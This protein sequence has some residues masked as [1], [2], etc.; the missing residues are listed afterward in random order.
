MRYTDNLNLKKPEQTEFYDV[1]DFNENA[2]K[3]DA[4]MMKRLSLSGGTITGTITS[5]SDTIL[6]KADDNSGLNLT[7]GKDN[8]SANL[9]LFGKS[10]PEFKGYFALDAL[11]DTGKYHQLLGTPDGKLSWGG[12]YFIKSINGNAADENGVLNVTKL[13]R[14]SYLSKGVNLND[15]QEIGVYGID[16]NGVAET[17]QNIP[18]PL[19]GMLE[20]KHSASDGYYVTQEYTTCDANTRR[21]VRNCYIKNQDWGE[22]VE[23]ITNKTIAT[24]TKYGVVRMATEEDALKDDVQDAAITPAVYHDVSDFRHKQTAYNLGDKVECMFNHELFLECTK[25]G[26]TASTPLDTR[27]VKYGQVLTDGTAQ[28]TVRTHIKSVNNTVA[29]ANGNVNVKE[30]THPNSGVQAGTYDSVTVNAQGH[31]TGGSNPTRVQ[32]VSISGRTITITFTDG[33]TKQLTTQD[34]NTVFGGNY[35]DLNFDLTGRMT[36]IYNGSTGIGDIQ[37]SQPYTNFKALLI[38]TCTDN[39]W[40]HSSHLI[41]VYELQ[42]RKAH[43]TNSRDYLLVDGYSFWSIAYE[44]STTTLIGSDDNCVIRAIYGIK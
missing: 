33:S 25:A 38:I 16:M 23:A 43:V 21:F 34:T 1:D 14:T 26:T 4:E 17:I 20:V 18:V 42:Q 24:S 8:S 44:S 3:I 15:Y 6:N 5:S 40:K 9:T 28:W 22:W 35:A 10:A 2:D 12:A 39:W 11:D 31:V 41:S 27:N 37:L 36:K 7:G 29:D 32:D 19:A 30:Y 13:E